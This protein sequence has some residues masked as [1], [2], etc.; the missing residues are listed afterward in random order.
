[1]RQGLF[2][3]TLT[4]DAAEALSPGQCE[5]IDGVIADYP[6]LTDDEFVRMHLDEWLS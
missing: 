5:R 1:M 4:L 3:N 6:H 2:G